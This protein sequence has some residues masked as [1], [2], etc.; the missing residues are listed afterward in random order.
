MMRIQE[1][2]DE[3]RQLHEGA[4]TRPG[5]VVLDLQGALARLTIDNPDARNA[6]TIGMMVELAEA[7]QRLAAW[8]GAALIVQATGSVFCAGGHLGDV[9]SRLLSE[10]AGLRMS[11]AMTTVLD[12]LAALPAVSIA[13]VHGPALGGGAEIVTA[14]DLRVVQPGAYAYFVHASLGV[15]PG[16]GGAQR[17]REIVGRPK[18]VHL[19]TTAARVDPEAGVAIGLFDQIADNAVAGAEAMLRPVL[20]LPRDAVRAAK[21]QVASVDRHAESEVF[22]RVWGGVAHREALSRVL[23]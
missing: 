23:R 3:L 19:L 7:V 6:L 20:A 16:W 17:L 10:G 14:T 2:I 9:H 4:A 1:A 12:A 5:R 18:A 22:A 11:R 13:A 15:S 8:D 21:L